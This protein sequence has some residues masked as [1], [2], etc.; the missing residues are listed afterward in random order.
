MNTQ[1]PKCQIA[2]NIEGLNM[3]PY[4]VYTNCRREELEG[5]M[6]ETWHADNCAFGYTI[7]D[8]SGVRKKSLWDFDDEEAAMEDAQFVIEGNLI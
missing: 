5:H 4:D 2:P 8:L 7:Y 1:K 3:N 6:I